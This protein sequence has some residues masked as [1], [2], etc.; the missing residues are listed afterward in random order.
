MLA[1]LLPADT[2]FLPTENMVKFV[3]RQVFAL[4]KQFDL[5]TAHVFTAV[6]FLAE[7]ELS[8]TAAESLQQTVKSNSQT[9]ISFSL[10]RN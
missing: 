9:A 4:L 6:Y 7:P 8:R 2:V 1:I 5:R 10:E 3:M